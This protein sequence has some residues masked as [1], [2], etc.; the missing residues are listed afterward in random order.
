MCNVVL[1]RKCKATY[2]KYVVYFKVLII[3]HLGVCGA[4]AKNS[5][6]LVSAGLLRH[7]EKQIKLC[8][9]IQFN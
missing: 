5:L 2:E 6:I 7:S 8:L 3:I 1:R 4:F 9:I